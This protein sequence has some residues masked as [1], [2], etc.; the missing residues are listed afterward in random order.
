MSNS[1]WKLIEQSAKVRV[2]KWLQLH[3]L[4]APFLLSPVRS[5]QFPVRFF[6][7]D[8]L[9]KARLSANN[10]GRSDGSSRKNLTWIFAVFFNIWPNGGKL[11]DVSDFDVQSINIWH[12]FARS[13]P[14]N[15]HRHETLQDE[16]GKLIARPFCTKMMI[17]FSRVNL[18]LSVAKF[19]YRTFPL[20]LNPA[21]DALFIDR[22]A[23]SG[24]RI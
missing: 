20:C 3:T 22:F 1:K 2:E 16:E 5:P 14:R 24:L 13:A 10:G 6:K 4:H 9:K 23:N 18:T 15:R 19:V 11:C 8:S 17:Q 21:K 7:A 12:C